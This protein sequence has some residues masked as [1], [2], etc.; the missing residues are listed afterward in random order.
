MRNA[1]LLGTRIVVGGYLAVHGAQK[2]FGSFDG[3]GL[4]AVAGGFEHLGLTPGRPMATLAGA[5]ELGGGI[6][7][8]TGIADPLGPMVI[9]GTMAVASATHRAKGPLSAKGGYELP[10]TNLAVAAA[11]AATGPGRWRLG[12]S[13]PTKL[14]RLSAAIGGALAALSLS[15]LLRAKPPAPAAAETATVAPDPEEAADPA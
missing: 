8:A 5:S 9:V 7:T 3:P 10:L 11:L 13:L 15:K 6:L 4:D 2:L 14:V 1:A 12:P